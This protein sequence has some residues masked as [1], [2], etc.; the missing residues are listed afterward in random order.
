MQRHYSMRLLESLESRRLL[1]AD[2]LADVR[3]IYPT[4]SVQI[5]EISYFAAD[6][7]VHGRELWRSDGTQAG[8][9]LVADLVVGAGGSDPASLVVFNNGVLFTAGGAIYRA[10][11]LG[12]TK[13]ADL[14]ADVVS[15]HAAVVNDRAIFFV[16]TDTAVDLWASD[17]TSGGTTNVTNLYTRSEA[18]P[19]R[20]TI[21][22][23]HLFRDGAM[24]KALGDRVLYLDAIGRLF[25][26]DGTEQGTTELATN[27]QDNVYARSIVLLDGE[28]LF[29]TY[30][31]IIEEIGENQVK[32]TFDGTCQLWRTDGTAAGTEMIH[33]TLGGTGHLVSTGESV[34]F[35]AEN[36][37]E[38]RSLW[39]TDGTTVGTR[40]VVELPE[41]AHLGIKHSLPDGRLLF[42]MGSDV[43]TDESSLWVSDGT[44]AG[45]VEV[46]S[47][48]TGF[49][50]M[51]MDSVSIGGVVYF[52][53]SGQ[54]NFSGR[55]MQLWRSDGTP[56]GTTLVQTYEKGGLSVVD[57]ALEIV[58]GKLAVITPE[59]TYILDPAS[60]SASIGPNQGR[61]TLADRVLR[62]FG[63]RNDDSIRV[64]RMS[65]NPDRFVVNLNGVKR[66]YA[67][68]DV[69]KI[70]VYGYS[71]D[72]NIAF[73]E[74]NGVVA[75][76]SMIRGGSGNDTVFGGS[77]RD[78]V[79]GED[80]DDFVHTSNSN[81]EAFGGSGD[82]TLLGMS[83]ADTLNGEEGADSVVGGSHQDVISGGFDQSDDIL[84]GGTGEDVVFGTA[85][86]EIF[87]GGEQGGDSLDDVLLA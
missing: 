86:F 54:A 82:D 36:E 57:S 33:L 20:L 26:T 23:V 42:V 11:A 51:G 32:V 66:S 15:T 81:D 53:Q 47:L 69:R 64:Y 27:E 7:G 80:G 79:W 70:I 71:G 21:L 12:A 4:D 61:T 29:L 48:G 34:Y 85:V 30:E 87:F 74:A 56:G 25:S 24:V 55:P 19:L 84:D 28:A 60:P 68:A 45:T 31:P 65:D 73:N 8:T 40:E 67:F 52:L 5:G 41:G 49:S 13:L 63:T 58:D 9:A 46:A 2:L 77:T 83:G 72:D 38:N 14:P 18:D 6:D 22:D 1:A 43:S 3:G 35:G 16:K 75:I 59:Q 10:D 37:Q 39:V 62:I 76:R 44:A 17:G 50:S 78:S